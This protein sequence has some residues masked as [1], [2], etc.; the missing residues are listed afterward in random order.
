MSKGKVIN[1]FSDGNRPITY[2]EQRFRAFALVESEL[3]NRNMSVRSSKPGVWDWNPSIEGSLIDYVD[4][5]E[6]DDL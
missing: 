2:A 1:L 6:G 4:E 3:R 5:A